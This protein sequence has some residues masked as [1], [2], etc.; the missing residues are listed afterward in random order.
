MAL[1]SGSVSSGGLLQLWPVAYA[2]MCTKFIEIDKSVFGSGRDLLIAV[3][4]RPPNTDIKLFIDAMRDVLERVQ[5]ENKL[6]YLVGEYKIN[7]LNV[8]SHSL[9]ADFNDTI[10]SYGLVPLITRPIRV[11]E[12]SA[13]LIDNIF[14][15]KNISYGE[16]MYGILV[17]DTSDHYPIFCIDKILKKKRKTINISYL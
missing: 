3:I 2:T 6:L 16:S 7:L 15:N 13:T 11:T 17:S 12:T 9:T 1:S 8:D 14:T 5:Q 10:Y 4:Y